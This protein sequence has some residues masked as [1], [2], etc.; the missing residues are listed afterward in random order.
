MFQENISQKFR[1][2]NIDDTRPYFIEEIKP[3]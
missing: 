1:L 3:K 2:I